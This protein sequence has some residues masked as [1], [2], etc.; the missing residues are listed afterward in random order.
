MA[1]NYITAEP[2]TLEEFLSLAADEG[3]KIGD[4]SII[5][6]DGRGCF[7]LSEEEYAEGVFVGMMNNPG[8]VPCVDVDSPRYNEITGEG[9][10]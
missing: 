5:H 4:R 3:F 6:P 1:D 9:D 2:I 10:E 7:G 8:I